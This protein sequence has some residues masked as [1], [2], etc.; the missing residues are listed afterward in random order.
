M[1]RILGC[2]R[3]NW[4][5]FGTPGFLKSIS[6]GD[7]N[8]R[9]SN[10]MQL[11]CPVK[12]N[13]MK[14]VFKLGAVLTLAASLAACNPGSLQTSNPSALEIQA[15][16]DAMTDEL[17]SSSSQVTLENSINSLSFGDSSQS[18]LRA[19]PACVTVT[20]SPLVDTDGDG[21]ADT[22]TYSFN[23]T[24]TG[25]FFSSSKTGTLVVN[26]PSSDALVWGF[27]STANLTE[28]RTNLTTGKT[29]TEVRKGSRSPRKTA[30]QVVQSH[31]ITV[32][33][34][35]TGEPD[36]T[37]TNLWNYTFNATTPGSIVMGQPLPAGTA[38]LAGNWSF[39]R[40]TKSRT[41]SVTTISP[42][43]YDPNCSEPLKIVAGKIRGTLVNN[44]GEGFIEITY[45]ACGTA[46]TITKSF[47]P[48][49]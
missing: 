7:R 19:K 1:E 17:L 18:N 3:F 25:V 5:V 2:S 29:V 26:D 16:S 22:A 30:D 15:T 28:S 31:N 27:D 14:N 42:L 4:N 12:G 39:S 32:T 13:T 49:V 45:N 48:G 37:I 40:D 33:R 34:S 23:C 8:T 11:A 36:A 10:L 47:T 24:K 44:S 46:P 43:Q 6:R 9:A 20:P 35:V 38:S 21:V 41:Y